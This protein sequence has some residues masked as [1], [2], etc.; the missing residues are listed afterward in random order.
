MTQHLPPNLL[1]LFQPRPPIPYIPP[2][3]KP[4]LPAYQGV[5]SFVSQFEDPATVDYTA[6]RKVETK[7]ERKDRKRKERLAKEEEKIA[8]ALKSC[9]CLCSSTPLFIKFQ[10]T[11][12][13]I[14]KPLEMPTRHCLFLVWYDLFL[15]LDSCLLCLEL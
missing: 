3:E 14:L 15:V 13:R 2:I 9:M 8:K 12:I 10:G 4:K 7:E 1:A 6:F 11:L 5:A